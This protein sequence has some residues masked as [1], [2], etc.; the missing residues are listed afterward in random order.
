MTNDEPPTL[1]AV[2][3]LIDRLDR[4]DRA[5]LRPWILARYEVDGRPHRRAGDDAPNERHRDDAGR[6]VRR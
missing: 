6:S 1:E 4:E 5:M 3:A 2:K